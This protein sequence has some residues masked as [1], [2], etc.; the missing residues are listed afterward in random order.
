MWLLPVVSS[1]L[2]SLA[3]PCGTA[4][5]DVGQQLVERQMRVLVGQAD[6]SLPTLRRQEL[7]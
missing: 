4:L 2:L 7:S 6:Q 1:E 5:L 3:A